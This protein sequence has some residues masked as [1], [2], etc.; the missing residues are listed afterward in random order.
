[1]EMHKQLNKP[2]FVVGSPRSGTSILSW[3]LGHH[4]NMFPVPESNWMGDFAVNLGIAY[5]IG[6]ARGDYSLLSA[7]DVQDDE[8]FAAFGRTINELIMRHQKDLEKKRE[9]RCVELNLD[10]RW[11]EATSAVSGPKKRWVDGTPEYSLHIFGLRKL[12]PDARFV[13]ILRDVRAVVCSML[14]FYRV[15]GTQLVRNEEEGY[16]YWLR[17]VRAC[18]KAEQ[19]YGPSVVHRIR[20]ADLVD[21]PESAMRSLLDFL[22]EPY[23]TRC[24][25]PLKQRINSSNVSPNFNAEDSTTNPAVVKE[26]TQLCA[27]IEETPQAAKASSTAADEMEAAFRERVKYVASAHKAYQKA[28]QII[29]TLKKSD[30]PSDAAIE[31][32]L[33]IANSSLSR[34]P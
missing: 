26:A 34:K 1:M 3:C 29:D 33:P 2:I 18:V 4:P 14:N 9:T 6:S 11:L 23:T 21:T 16:R 27:E 17:T 25:R 12:F 5:Q 15:A 24:L 10:R 22:A 31:A 7:M 13:H 19:A 32:M 30:L 28:R 20:Y 8:V